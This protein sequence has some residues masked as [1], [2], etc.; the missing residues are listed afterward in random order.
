VIGRTRV[1][2]GA[3]RARLASRF[4]WFAIALQTLQDDRRMAGSV[5]AAGVAF[6]LLLMILPL[7]LLTAALLGFENA[8]AVGSP[9]QVA[10]RYGLTVA[11]ARTIQSSATQA[12]KGRWF[13]LATGLLLLLWTGNGV[14]QGLNGAFRV[15]W[16]LPHTE[17]GSPI[18]ALLIVASLVLA[19]FAT[20]AT[21][22]I[23]AGSPGL[24]A[25]RT[26]GLTLTYAILWYA[27]SWALPHADADWRALLPG[28]ILFALGFALLHLGTVLFVANRVARASQLYGSLG[29][30]S[31]LMLWLFLS[32]RLMVGSA[33]L[34]ATLWRRRGG[35]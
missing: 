28:S 1:F 34:N 30:I 29:F 20:V 7:A 33:Q 4:R 14:V 25:P 17:R 15:A 26:A 5:M 2:L 13:L 31:T 3:R 10:S 27:I 16:N 21:A 24:E 32:G 11:L 9:G 22:S 6:R 19:V 8:T 23:G 35:A 18:K 12:T